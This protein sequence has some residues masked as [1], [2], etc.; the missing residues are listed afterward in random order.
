MKGADELRELIEKYDGVITTKDA[1]NEGIHR[2]YLRELMDDG[3]LVRVSY[4]IYMTKD[5]WEDGLYF[6]QLRK[7]K[8]IYS[9]E[10]ALYLH[11]LTDRDPLKYVVTFPSGYNPSKLKDN[12]F[13]VHTVKKEFFDLGVLLIETNFGNKVKTYNMERTICDIL[14]DRNNQDP[15]ILI[16]S[17][18]EYFK[19]KD[20]NL[21]LLMSY[22][23]ILRVEAILEPYL[24]VLL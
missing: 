23:K 11:N 14:R 8:M 9:H 21:N 7:K 12:G 3:E 2:Q 10:T 24:N 6:Q 1:E 13:I 20:K 19:R 4:G 18:K 15:A 16:E 22:A 5:S 17:L